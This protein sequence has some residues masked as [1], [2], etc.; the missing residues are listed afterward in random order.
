MRPPRSTSSGSECPGW[1]HQ[2]Q[3]TEPPDADP[4][5]RW[6]G[7]GV[8]GIAGYPLSRSQHD[9]WPDGPP[10]VQKCAMA[11]LRRGGRAIQH[12]VGRQ[13]HTR[14]R[15]GGG[16][17]RFATVRVPKCTRARPGLCECA[18]CHPRLARRSLRGPGHHED[19][20]PVCLTRPFRRREQRPGEEG[21]AD[22]GPG[23]RRR[24][25]LSL[26]GIVQTLLQ[27]AQPWGRDRGG[28]I[29]SGR[30][31]WRRGRCGGPVEVSPRAL[32]ARRSRRLPD[33]GGLSVDR[34]LT[35]ARHPAHTD[36]HRHRTP[37]WRE[38]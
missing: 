2:P 6:C 34:R 22:Q 5:V 4:H 33:S 32:F 16:V 26:A 24:H 20:P 13:A 17:V 35:E 21:E 27:P 7:R 36:I 30:A 18:T 29:G 19:A 25:G 37:A 12:P 38:S 1:P 8:A 9:W 28:S 10:G 11:G 3:L 31:P 23:S 15:P 14:R